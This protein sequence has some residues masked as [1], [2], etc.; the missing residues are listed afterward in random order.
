M[1][2]EKKSYNYNMWTAEERKVSNVLGILPSSFMILSS[3]VT[4]CHMQT[5]L[6]EHVLKCVCLVKASRSSISF[7]A[8]IPIIN[9]ERLSLTA[10]L[11]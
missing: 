6:A 3:K 9:E 11:S 8:S 4:T 10:G 2:L 5:C 1:A 7:S